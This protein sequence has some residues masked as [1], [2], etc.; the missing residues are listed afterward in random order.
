MMITLFLSTLFVLSQSHLCSLNPYQRGGMVS[1][2]ELSVRGA[3]E[4]YNPDVGAN[5]Q[6]TGSWPCYKMTTDDERISNF[7]GRN[8]RQIMFAQKNLDHYN[9]NNPGNFTWNLFTFN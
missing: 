9:P 1:D 3:I 5:G 6:S 8:A 7:I 2:S 4:C